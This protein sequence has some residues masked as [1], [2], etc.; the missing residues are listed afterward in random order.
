[1][2]VSVGDYLGFNWQRGGFS[3]LTVQQRSPV[4]ALVLPKKT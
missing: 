1:M 4:G 2:G 3:P